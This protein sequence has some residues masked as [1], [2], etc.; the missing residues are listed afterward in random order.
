MAENKTKPTD[1]SIE[2]FINAL[3]TAKK[4]EDGFHVLEMMKRISG[5]EP[6]MWG[7]SIIGFDNVHYETKS[8]HEG[9]MPKLCYSPRK[10][11]MVLYVL[12]DFEG[13]E[14]L[15]EKVGKHKT[16]RICLYIN[17][18]ADVDLAVLEQIIQASWDKAN[19]KKKKNLRDL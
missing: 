11:R 7:S 16:G 3:P 4:I 14:E 17:K 18:L 12:N 19:A 9:D 1:A 10:Q 8:G 5:Q 15:L 6:V 13:Q 2:D